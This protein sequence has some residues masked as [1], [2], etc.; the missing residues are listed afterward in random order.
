MPG[1]GDTT[2][3][4]VAIDCGIQLLA[5]HATRATSTL[6]VLDEGG[7]EGELLLAGAF[8][9]ELWG[10]V[11]AR[12][13]VLLVGGGID[14]VLLALFTPEIGLLHVCKLNS[15]EGDLLVFHNVPVDNDIV[16]LAV[17]VVDECGFIAE[18]GAACK[19]LILVDL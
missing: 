12:S 6:Q 18:V 4:I 9:G 5:C 17:E 1:H 10:L 3:S 8:D 2:I 14:E 7:H 16:T 13:L 11:L 19:T 15:G